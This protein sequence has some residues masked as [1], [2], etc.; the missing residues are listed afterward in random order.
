MD[1]RELAADY[2]RDG[3]VRVRGFFDPDTLATVRR[4]LARYEREIVPGLPPGDRTLE[5]DGR[6]V[7]NL[8]RMDEHDAFFNSLAR[9]ADAVE[10]VRHLVH[11]EPVLMGVETFNKPARIGSGVP[12]H[13]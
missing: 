7:R 6:T 10:L 3:C 2:E 5:A 11:G 1:K 13:Q 4:E 8:W 12:P 9:R